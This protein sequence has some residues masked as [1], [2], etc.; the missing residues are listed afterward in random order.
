MRYISIFPTNAHFEA[1]TQSFPRLDSLYV[2]LVPRNDILNND[3]KMAQVDAEDLWMERNN[4]YATVMRELFSQPPTH[5]FLHLK[6]FESG[7]AADQDAWA[8][9]VEYVKR[10]DNGWKVAG[11]GVFIKDPNF[12]DPNTRNQPAN[13]EAVSSMSVT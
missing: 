12:S 4:C 1:L 8:M 5:N 7:D 9:A 11:E 13:A 2:Q 10:A 3:S 6:E